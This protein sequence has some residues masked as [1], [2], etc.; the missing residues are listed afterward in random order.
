MADYRNIF[1]LDIGNKFLNDTGN[2]I[3]GY[4]LDYVHL[5]SISY[6]VW[7]DA[8]QPTIDWIMKFIC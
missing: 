8:M 7:A 1:Y 6:Q 3:P 2:F 4:T 5:T